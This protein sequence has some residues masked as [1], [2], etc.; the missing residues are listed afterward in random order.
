[1]LRLVEKEWRATEG[2]NVRNLYDVRGGP[3]RECAR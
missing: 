3:H 1:M 2:S